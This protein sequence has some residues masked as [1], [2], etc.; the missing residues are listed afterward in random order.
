MEIVSN[1]L[2]TMGFEKQTGKMQWIASGGINTSLE[3]TWG[4]YTLFDHAF[5]CSN[6]PSLFL[7]QC[8]GSFFCP[9]TSTKGSVLM[10]CHL[11]EYQ[12]GYQSTGAVQ[13]TLDSTSDMHLFQSTI[14]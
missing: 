7:G 14:C 6:V 13:T 10:E 9:S 2:I 12:S 1:G 3:Q 11:C 8:W 4:Y 5:D